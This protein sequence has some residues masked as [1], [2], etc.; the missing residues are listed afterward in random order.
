MVPTLPKPREWADGAPGD[1]WPTTL[2]EP[3]SMARR[4]LD[5]LLG[6]D[7][8][9]IERP[10]ALTNRRIL[11]VATT[12][13]LLAVALLFPAVGD[14]G[15]VSASTTR[16]VSA[17][18]VGTYLLSLVCFAWWTHGQRLTIDQLRWRSFKRPTWSGWWA[19]GWVAIPLVGLALAIAVSTEDSNRL[20]YAGLAV[21]LVAARV[22]SLQALGTNMGRVVRGAKRW[23]WLWGVVAGLVDLLMIDIVVTGLV[24]ADPD[25]ARLDLLT[26]WTLP[27]LVVSML[28]VVS[29][30]KRVER[31]VLEWWDHRYGLGDDEVIAVLLA[32]N[33]DAS[34]HATF[35]GR[36]L[37][38]TAPL[39]V[40]VFLTYL[41]VAVAALWNGRTIWDE[42]DVLSLATDAGGVIDDLW[43]SALVFAGAVIAVQIVQGAW[44]MAAAWNARRCTVKAP[45]VVGMLVL[46][47]LGPAL[48]VVGLNLAD[49][50]GM[51]LM[52]VGMALFLNLVCWG[53]SFSVLSQTLHVL[54]RSGELMT[55]WGITVAMH[56]VLAF[57][58]RPLGRVEDDLLYA[59]IAVL[60]SV[61]DAV[62]FVIASVY[63]WR[64]MRHFDEATRSYAQVRRVS[65]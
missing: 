30:L 3:V 27:F 13:A 7:E 46:F 39:R 37:L 2:P 10:P 34:G 9:P 51:R 16:S 55:T 32:V 18:F 23:L 49:D 4:D 65:V 5:R 56:W 58:F 50:D 31:W 15:E 14:A 57:A 6:S 48:L 42:R 20:W 29:Y 38:P 22:M 19:V 52:V 59:R 45:N 26:A 53:F 21:G 12:V 54:R 41:F 40:A 36:R 33:R 44:S 47:L 60:L 62:I 17:L 63:A 11:T 24:E 8:P 61:L 35:S 1:V 43:T 28:F 25:P 64:A